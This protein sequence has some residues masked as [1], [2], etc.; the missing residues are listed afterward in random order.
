MRNNLVKFYLWYY[1]GFFFFLLLSI[2]DNLIFLNKGY[3]ILVLEDN[4]I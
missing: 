3:I 4:G 2:C 1:I